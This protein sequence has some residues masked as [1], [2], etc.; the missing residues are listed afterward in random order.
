MKV[1]V[2]GASGFL[3][4]H[5][6]QAFLRRGAAVRAMVRPAASLEALGWSPEV[7]VVRAD[8]RVAEDLDRTL[9]GVDALVHLAA[10]VAG[11]DDTR[12]ASTV[13]GTDGILPGRNDSELTTSG[14]GV[15]KALAE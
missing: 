14:P 10:C 3:G 2:T 9:A 6:V 1:L 5:V 7:E 8:L 13:V 15:E 12:F 4:R 11:D